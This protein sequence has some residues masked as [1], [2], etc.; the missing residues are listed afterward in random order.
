MLENI[1]KIGPFIHFIMFQENKMKKN[2]Y[3]K[4]EALAKPM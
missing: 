2:A 4:L 1:Q 3:E